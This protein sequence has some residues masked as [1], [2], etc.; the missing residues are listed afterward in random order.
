MNPGCFTSSLI[1]FHGKSNDALLKSI[2]N[3]G[4][5][6]GYGGTRLRDDKRPNSVMIPFQSVAV[7]FHRS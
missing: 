4:N 2:F 3:L 5:Q 6:K 1:V 7:V